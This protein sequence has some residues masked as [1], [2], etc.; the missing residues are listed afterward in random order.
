MATKRLFFSVQEMILLAL[1]GALWA[2]IEI[3]IGLL[4][5]LVK[6]PFAGILLTFLGILILL[7][8]RAFVPRP[9]TTLLI[10]IVAALSTFLFLGAIVIYPM[11]GIFMESLLVEI[12]LAFPLPARVNF[13]VA[14]ILGM[15]W[16]FFHPFIVQGLIA[17]LGFF[18][19]YSIVVE[20]GARLFHLLPQQV[21][22]ILILLVSVFVLSGFVAGVVGWNLAVRLRHMV[23]YPWLSPNS[24][25]EPV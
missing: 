4:L 24:L 12:G 19:I 11:I 7:V 13:R 18:K 5:H 16:S 6:L 25:R 14:G 1:L 17:G 15:L 21:V 20:K 10:G 2:A 22:A 9:G 8:G 3:H 23:S